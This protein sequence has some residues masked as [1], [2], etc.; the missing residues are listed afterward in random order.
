MLKKYLI[1]KETI[2]HKMVLDI[3]EQTAVG[4]VETVYYSPEVLGGGRLHGSSMSCIC[5]DIHR[6]HLTWSD[7]NSMDDLMPKTNAA[8]SLS[9]RLRAEINQLVAE[10]KLDGKSVSKNAD[11]QSVA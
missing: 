8:K 9:R 2:V 5:H 6:R 10:G 3:V 11:R 1:R 4:L 7:V